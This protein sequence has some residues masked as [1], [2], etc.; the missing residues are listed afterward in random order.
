M[1]ARWERVWREELRGAEAALD[2]LP[3]GASAL[4]YLHARLGF[5]AGCSLRALHDSG[6]SWGTY[7]D[8]MC[9][10]SQWHNNSHA[11]NFVVVPE[12]AAEG[13]TGRFLSVLDLD[14]AFSAASFVDLRT[15]AVGKRPAA[16]ARL[17][18]FE[19]ACSAESIAAPV[20]QNLLSYVEAR[21]REAGPAAAWAQ[22]AL[23]DTMLLAFFSAYRGEAAAGG[24]A[25]PPADARLHAAAH[26]LLR[27]ALVIQANYL[28]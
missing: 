16:F 13:G 27:L 11:N 28:A 1:G 5:D 24:G 8:K 26:A 20:P 9:H 10:P 19:A 21:Q 23:S 22:T 18:A 15:G 14:M 17:L 25:P 7:W 2:A 4:A 3:A 6:L 12:G